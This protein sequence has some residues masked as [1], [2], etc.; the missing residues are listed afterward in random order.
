MKL[1]CLKVSA[2]LQFHQDPEKRSQVLIRE[3]FSKLKA[4]PSDVLLL[5]F[6]FFYLNDNFEV[7][8]SLSLKIILTFRAET[9]AEWPI[10]CFNMSEKYC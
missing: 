2:K 4:L 3:F 6:E 5:S 8:Q 9:S 10:F 7:N 1:S